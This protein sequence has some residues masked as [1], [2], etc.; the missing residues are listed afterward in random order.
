MKFIT[1]KI[2]NYFPNYRNILGEERKLEKIIKPIPNVHLK[3]KHP[4]METDELFEVLFDKGDEEL[5]KIEKDFVDSQ[6]D[7]QLAKNFV[8]ESEYGRSLAVNELTLNNYKLVQDEFE[9]P[10]KEP[11]NFTLN[12]FIVRKISI[13]TELILKENF[14]IMNNYIIRFVQ[15]GSNNI[16]GDVNVID[17]Y[18][19]FLRFCKK[20]LMES[21]SN[22]KKRDK[23]ISKRFKL[24]EHSVRDFVDNE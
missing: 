24:T 4:N 17:A 16:E 10:Y 8:R 19:E 11:V 15:N 2:K 20:I 5:S 23:E 6:L 22:K 9:N 1:E 13:E 12:Y 14:P 21:Y 7:I 3:E 18:S